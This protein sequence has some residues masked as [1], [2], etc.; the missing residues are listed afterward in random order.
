MKRAWI[1]G[2]ILVLLCAALALARSA[3]PIVNTADNGVT[4][5]Y[6]DLASH[7]RL[8]VGPYS[9]FHWHHPGPLYFFVQAPLYVAS[10]RAGAALYAGAWALNLAAFALLL[11]T[12]AEEGS[13][14]L[15]AGVGIAVLVL[16][17][18][19]PDVLASP[20]TAHVTILPYLAYVTAAAAAAAGRTDLLPVVT[21]VASFVAQTNLSLVPA[22]AVPLALLTP[23]IVR[24]LRS[25][26]TGGRH[27]VV[28][29]A[30]ALL[31]WLPVIA[32]MLMHRGGNVAA[33]WTFFASGGTR[34]SFRE[35]FAA[36]SYTVVG[37]A[38]SNLELPGGKALD[39][40]GAPWAPAAAVV[41]TALP[42]ALAM[43]G[44]RP[45][46]AWLGAMVA[47]S[48][49]VMLWSITRIVDPIG[50]YQVLPAAALGT[51][52]A[53]I[54]L[55]GVAR[56]VFRGVERNSRQRYALLAAM[57]IAAC[58]IGVIQFRRGVGL[59]QRLPWAADV[60]P[61]VER[62][63]AYLDSRRSRA[64]VVDVDRAW[65]QS[66]PI[67]L[68]LRQHHRRISV[69]PGNLFMFT[70]VFA[71]TGKEDTRLTVQP[72]R[73]AAAAGSATIFDSFTISV[74]SRSPDQ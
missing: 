31:V 16:A 74:L 54:V 50:D 14:A 17:W 15:T 38:R 26:G 56:A 37:V 30:V 53:G 11:G 24:A 61:A 36:W 40:S 43:R 60:G 67:V 55:A 3:P 39:P 48:L 2:A 66:V 42:V 62:I 57:Y 22:V 4:E 73:Q 71:P 46:E 25:P 47:A 27:V 69:T 65:S 59:Q 7:G 6:V 49:V 64:T 13:A 45:F 41:I 20:W 51:M 8:L 28:A 23:A 63:E 19:M 1:A 33:L 35:A 21:F 32:E 58:A 34:H 18:R 68:R 52:A 70:D 29:A 9:R 10:G 12:L 44:K 72:G 5:L